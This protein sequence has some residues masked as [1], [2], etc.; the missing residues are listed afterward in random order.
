MEKKDIINKEP[1]YKVGEEVVCKINGETAYIVH[2]FRA[3]I[4]KFVRAV[5]VIPEDFLGLEKVATCKKLKRPRFLKGDKVNFF[6]GDKDLVGEVF[7]V[8]WFYVIHLHK[9]GELKVVLAG[10]LAKKG[11]KIFPG[12]LRPAPGQNFGRD[13]NYG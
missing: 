11:T 13:I 9:S 12:V 2:S 5:N 10:I 6:N 7:A 8:Y 3:C 1:K 4:V